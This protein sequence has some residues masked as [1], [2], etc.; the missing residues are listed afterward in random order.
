MTEKEMQLELEGN[1]V[2][3][4][5]F[6]VMLHHSMEITRDLLFACHRLKNLEI[7]EGICTN[8]ERL[9]E[10]MDKITEE[11]NKLLN[12]S[13]ETVAMCRETSFYYQHTEFDKMNDSLL[14]FERNMETVWS[15]C[16]PN[17]ND[18]FEKIRLG[19]ESEQYKRIL[20]LREIIDKSEELSSVDD[21]FLHSLCD[22]IDRPD[23]CVKYWMTEEEFEK[24]KSIVEKY[25][26]TEQDINYMV[27]YKFHS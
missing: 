16:A 9:E 7:P 27:A 1:E 19:E 15:R 24:K 2:K 18:R 4:N 23:D 10:R 3:D 17:R 13:D 20:E 21:S 25:E 12:M 22:V 11:F 26:L 6:D 14:K 5:P 8:L